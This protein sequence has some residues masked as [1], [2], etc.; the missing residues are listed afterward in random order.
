MKTKIILSAFLFSLL[1]F[2]SCK[3]EIKVDGPVAVQKEQTK[4]IYVHMMTWFWTDVD[5]IHP[6]KESK[7]N[8]WFGHWT[9]DTKNPEIIDSVTGQRQIATHYYPLTGPYASR[10]KNIIEY[11]LL[12]M[13]LAG[14]DGIIFNYSTLNPAWDFP[15]LI[16]ATDSIAK[17]TQR[18]G[19]EFAIMYE[20]QHVRDAANRKELNMDS[21]S[22]AKEDMKYIKERYFLEP[23]YIKVDGRPVL[24]DFGPQY[25]TTE[26][27]WT[28]IFSVF[29]EEQPA[30]YALNYHGARAGKNL[31]GEY[32]WIWKDYL[33]GLRHFYNTYEFAGDKMGV[34][35]PG[36][37]DF[38]KDGGWG[39]GIGWTI[40][41]RGDSTF[42]ETLQ[43]ALS[44]QVNMIQLATW[45]DYGEG[46]MIE[47]TKE[48]GYSFLTALQRELKVK[49][50]SQKD[51]E[52]V[53]DFYQ[54]RLK[55]AGNAEAQQ[56]LDKAFDLMTALRMDEA[57]KI[58]D[59]LK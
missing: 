4:K 1:A 48:F 18:V 55:N 34:A 36:F 9:M 22:R 30:F 35:Y 50:L 41:H 15:K 58:I 54:A 11:Q 56:K 46:T 53:F 10:D 20:D 14:I 40:P 45:N 8:P 38:Y 44:S 16:E 13:K 59:K 32:A 23:N 12:L 21:M 37:V 5:N 42:V 17:M 24:L 6:E 31:Y 39:D 25:F 33:D 2:F 47:P 7:N 28:E 3:Q 26:E 49:D 57:R 52:L 27:Q 43:L 19:L 51:L 29:G